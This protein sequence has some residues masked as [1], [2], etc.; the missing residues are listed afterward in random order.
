MRFFSIVF[1]IFAIH[2]FACFLDAQD[3]TIPELGI[4]AHG[5]YVHGDIDH[6]DLATGNVYGEIPLVSFPQKGKLGSLEFMLTFNTAPFVLSQD[7]SDDRIFC[8]QYYAM[9][10]E[11]GG[12]VQVKSNFN[13]SHVDVYAPIWSPMSY[14]NPNTGLCWSPRFG[15][16]Y[17][18]YTDATGRTHKL[19]TND[20]NLD[21]A[22]SIDGSG[23][24]FDVR[25]SYNPFDTA[26]PMKT[27]DGTL[28]DPL[29]VAYR[30]L[31]KDFY[32]ESEAIDTLGNKM[33]RLGPQIYYVGDP[34]GKPRFEDSI[35]R[36]IPDVERLAFSHETENS[37]GGVDKTI[38]YNIE[39]CPD[40]KLPEQQAEYT[41]RWTVPNSEGGS[42]TYLFCYTHVMYDLGFYQGGNGYF[43]WTYPQTLEGDPLQSPIP[44]LREPQS[45]YNVDTAGSTRAIQSVVLPDGK[46]WSFIYDAS[47]DT[48]KDGYQVYTEAYGSIKEIRYPT[49][50]K[51]SFTYETR[52]LCACTYPGYQVFRAVK[53]RIAEDGNGN[54]EIREFS[55]SN[56]KTKNEYVTTETDGLGNQTVHTF[57]DFANSEQLY[58][59]QT[60]IYEGAVKGTPLR[61]VKNEYQYLEDIGSPVPVSTYVVGGITNVLPIRTTTIE[62]GVVHD[63]VQKSYPPLFTAVRIYCGVP[64][65]V[66]DRCF[67]A[68]NSDNS[69]YKINVNS[70][71]PS[72]TTIYDGDG[73]MLVSNEARPFYLDNSEYKNANLI[74]LIGTKSIYLESLLPGGQ[75]SSFERTRTEYEYDK[76]KDSPKG[77]LGN[78][79]AIIRNP[80]DGND[81]IRT[82]IEYNQSGMPISFRDARGGF[83]YYNYDSSGLY[84]SKRTN[85]LGQAEFFKYDSN[86][87]MLK[88]YTD[89]NGVKRSYSYDDLNRMTLAVIGVGAIN[90]EGDNVETRTHYSYPGPN[91]VIMLQDKDRVDDKVVSS[92]IDFDGRG[93]KVK[94]VLPD[95]SQ[96]DTTYD[97][98]GR[99]GAVSLPYFA[100]SDQK[101]SSI[102]YA[103]DALGR[104]RYLCQPENGTGDNCVPGKAYQEYQ[105]GSNS[106]DFWDE[107]RKHWIRKYDSLRRLVSVFEPDSSNNPIIETDYGYDGLGNLIQVDQWEE[108]KGSTV[109]SRSFAYDSFSR[110]ISALN[111][112]SGK[113]TYSYDKNSN[114]ISKIDARGIVTSYSYDNLNRLV[115]KS[116]DKDPYGTPASYYS[117]DVAQGSP[118]LVS[119][120][121]SDLTAYRIGRLAEEHT[122]D[123][124]S[125]IV[126][127]YDPLGR[128]TAKTECTPLNCVKSPYELR[129]KYDLT[130]NVTQWNISG[131]SGTGSVFKNEFDSANRLSAVENLTTEDHLYSAVKWGPTGIVDYTLGGNINVHKD[132]DIRSRAY[133][134]MS[135][136]LIQ[137]GPTKSVG[138]LI[139][140]GDLQ[141]ID[142]PTKS[143]GIFTINGTIQSGDRTGYSYSYGSGSITFS[144]QVQSGPDYSKLITAGKVATMLIRVSGEIQTVSPD[145]ENC[146]AQENPEDCWLYDSGT[147]NI[148]FADH[149]WQ[150]KYDKNTTLE[151]LAVQIANLL[152]GT[153]LVTASAS[154]DKTVKYDAWSISVMAKI[155]GEKGSY[156]Y[157]TTLSSDYPLYFSSA[158]FNVDGQGMSGGVDPKYELVYDSGRLSVAV[159]SCE[160]SAAYDRNTGTA[161][162]VSSLA[163][164]L[165]A[166]CGSIVGAT[167]AGSQLNLMSKTPGETGNYGITW[168]STSDNPGVFAVGSFQGVLSASSLTGGTTT[169]VTRTVTDHGTISLSAGSKTKTISYGPG[170]TPQALAGRMAV[171]INA[172]DSFPVTGLPA[173]GSVSFIKLKSRVRG[174]VANFFVSASTAFDQDNF[175]SSSFPVQGV[176]LVGGV[177]GS[178]EPLW[179]QGTIT[180]SVGPS[181][182]TVSYGE[183]DDPFT[184][185][186][187]LTKSFAGDSVVQVTSAGPELKLESV[188]R[189]VAVN[190]SY[191]LA[192]THDAIH[193]DAPSFGMNSSASAMSGGADSFLTPGVVYGYKLDYEPNGNIRSVVDNVMG[194]WSYG[195]DFVNRLISAEASTG[196]CA[197]MKLGWSYD[198][199]GNRASQSLSGGSAC[200]AVQ[201]SLSFDEHNRISG[202][203][204]DSSGNVTSDGFNR[205]DYDGEGRLATANGSVRYIYDVE[206][207]RIAKVNGSGAVI[208]SY[209]V[210]LGGEQVGEEDG[211]GKMVHQNVF[212]GGSLLGTYDDNGLHYHLND[213]L[214]TRRVQMSKNG[215]LDLS[216]FSL[217]FGDGL[218]CSGS[219]ADATEHHFTGK[220]RD[221]ESVNDYF[222][223]RYY[224]SNLGSFLSPD[225]LMA[226]AKASNP[227]TWNRYSYVLNNPLKLI[228]PNGMEVSSQCA[229]DKN[230]QINVR[231]NVIYDQSVHGGK[232]L[233]DKER[234]SFEAKLGKAKNDYLSSNINLK[235]TYTPGSYSVDSKG[236]TK[237]EGLR[238]DSLNLVVSN[239]TP[240]VTHSGDSGTM[241]GYAVTFLNFNTIQGSNF[242]LG[243]NTVEHEMGH[244][245]LGDPY[246]GV[247]PSTWDQLTRDYQIDS[248]NTLQGL[249]VSQGAYRQGLEPRKF[250][251]DANPEANK[252]QQ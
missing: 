92:E 49:G 135:N 211:T 113:I 227:Q 165:N 240:S 119:G 89:L 166:N 121:A 125:Q 8:Y 88:E 182:R 61:T 102:S 26:N 215:V 103:Y 105:Y 128:I 90:T 173:D 249:G 51:V 191:Q 239:T 80:Y 230:C 68:V 206:G 220:E 57:I 27:V 3:V 155:E 203:G 101:V 124:S 185:A 48:V 151:S 32:S 152:N 76:G 2:V 107:N 7:C 15:T 163:S 108:G 120:Y 192:E 37:S 36:I 210:G 81:S 159:N 236:N 91:Q 16:R 6:I 71:V 217:P 73:N 212:A 54:K 13:G 193:F 123:N 20:A 34:K 198:N 137:T 97:S 178:G 111:P 225:P 184:I 127:T 169:V 18:S 232:G 164:S 207:N 147:L 161:F 29:G 179:D 58:E 40:L 22:Y 226:S 130:G 94:E 228:D 250:A 114:L 35:G 112:E 209:I 85:T 41:V 246:S 244:Q 77:I 229:N 10:E 129:Y 70:S 156:S 25:N 157:S 11:G 158:S 50:G 231:I 55:Y 106:V 79:T 64:Y 38:S 98:V 167:V 252:P 100:G 222:G 195:Y 213:W 200:A 160:G 78:Q 199:F 223:A 208:T 82:E 237:V 197:G 28:Y 47:Q 243:S 122:S 180:L 65:E 74:S 202:F 132:Y 188:G 224:E 144:G 251:V 181:S 45:W 177:D 96:I 190:Y 145:A 162:L 14:C 196:V 66:D 23:Y 143:S 86:T 248:R 104:L 150:L 62:R 39:G 131:S 95:G 168:S 242:F 146:S 140:S 43:D 9:P 142:T 154:P 75:K 187:K 194:S 133:Q 172:D 204:Y 153:G 99:V 24:R 93:R 149:S 183:D 63:I 59:K 117:Y 33:E 52:H 241:G 46:A 171:A 60:D 218:Q 245:F 234:Q 116:Y 53:S 219:A 17:Y 134:E 1:T 189:G 19:F 110:L 214:G 4:K 84:L 247:R 83:G 141:G 21:Q 221:F 118:S 174:S 170:D 109:R 205:Y 238:D 139:L 186:A 201:P 72:T 87:G 44:E 175:A 126:Y 42:A 233:T 30:A 67:Y 12:G 31:D 136:G 148:Y 5:S 115:K 235:I 176:Q 56:G 216:C 138:S 69:I